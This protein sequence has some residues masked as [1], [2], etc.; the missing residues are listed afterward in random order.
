[1]G[2]ELDLQTIE[3]DVAAS[4][5]LAAYIEAK[6]KIKEWQEKADLAAEQIKSAMGDHEVGL[7]DGAPAVKWVTV[8]SRA[9]DIKK[10]RE[11]L[12]PQVLDLVE[13]VRKSKRFTLI[14]DAD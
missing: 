13:V 4:A 9:L 7:I 14:G 2:T 6:N 12:P 10:C 8:E 3:L 5:F 11:I 1:M